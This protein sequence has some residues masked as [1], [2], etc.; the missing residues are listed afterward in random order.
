MSKYNMFIE[1][2]GEYLVVS[3]SYIY[4]HTRSSSAIP[5]CF[6]PTLLLR[7]EFRHNLRRARGLLCCCLQGFVQ[8][9]LLKRDGSMKTKPISPLCTLL[10]TLTRALR[11]L[12]SFWDTMH[13]RLALGSSGVSCLG[14]L[15]V[16]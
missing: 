15:H 9:H 10:E 12:A 3:S 16:C 2:T 1:K 5:T 13:G 4:C 11:A 14:S 7:W 8:T 6:S